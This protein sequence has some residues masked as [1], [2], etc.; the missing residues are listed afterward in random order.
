M[1]YQFPLLFIAYY[2]LLYVY[3]HY[4]TLTFKYIS[5]IRNSSVNFIMEHSTGSPYNR[6]RLHCHAKVSNSSEA[7]TW[8]EML[9]LA[10]CA[11]NELASTRFGIRPKRE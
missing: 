9:V 2:L 10:S 7:S 4:D 5:K 3:F 8:G 1:I 11:T 6:T